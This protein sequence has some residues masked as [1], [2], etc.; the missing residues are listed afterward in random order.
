MSES[1]KERA[2]TVQWHVLH[3]LKGESG[4]VPAREAIERVES[5]LTL[6]EEEKAHYE[7][8]P[9]VRRFN[10]RLRFATISLVKAGW[11]VKE[12]AGWSIADEGL[13]ALNRFRS[14]M[15]LH[16]ES[17]RLYYEW[18]DSQPAKPDADDME[19][20]GED[21]GATPSTLLEEADESAWQEISDYLAAMP[22]YDFQKLVGALLKAMGYHV[23]WIAPV[24]KD[25][26]ID[27][28]AHLDPL[29]T[30]PPRIKVQVKRQSSSRISVD[31]L[32]S[33]MAVLG[34]EDVGIF[35]A[36]GGFTR[37]AEW[38]ARTQEKRRVTLLDAEKLFELWV[39]HYDKVAETEK[40]FLPLKPVYFLDPNG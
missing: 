5:K 34:D 21:E 2:A 16:E 27:I 26:G 9:G 11:L 1:S 22:P 10:N 31:G 20:A 8:S 15:Q 37:D 29:G 18:H 35:V 38:E 33:F 13:A 4:P 24:G 14:P 6:T 32:R 36:L 7:K 3:A 19:E 28:L 25:G 23:A 12:R 40:S 39:Q 30:R 17:E